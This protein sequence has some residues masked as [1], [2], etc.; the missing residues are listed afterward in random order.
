MN[1]GT[2]QGDDDMNDIIQAIMDRRSIRKYK[3]DPV[4]AAERDLI[5]RAGLAAPSSKNTQPWHITV[6]E[7]PEVIAK[8]TE[9][10]KA[11]IVRANFERYIAMTGNP[12][13]TVNYGAPLFMMVSADPSATFC[14]AEDASMVLANMFLAAHSLGIGSCW[15]NQL[16]PVCDE[17]A[18]RAF[19]ATLGVP[20]ANR[21]YGSVCFGYSAAAH[22]SAPPRR[23]GAVNFA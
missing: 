20:A 17:P 5:I 10:L 23:E 14:P 1:K 6:V 11:A 2:F 16:G 19:L 12:K 13:Y 3:P 4:P 8:I 7:K 18:F 21:I 22:P 9:E 15:I